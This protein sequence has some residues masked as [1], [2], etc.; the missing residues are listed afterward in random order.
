MRVT[1][2][3]RPVLRGV[4]ALGIRLAA[5]TGRGLPRRGAGV[6]GLHL[7]WGIA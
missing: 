3:P 5:V 4:V 7:G 1:S 2:V 6:E